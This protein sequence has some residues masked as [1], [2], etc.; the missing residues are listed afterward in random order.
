MV[1]MPPVDDFMKLFNF[2]SCNSYFRIDVNDPDSIKDESGKISK[3]KSKKVLYS[4]GAYLNIVD[5]I[6]PLLPKE[7]KDSKP[8]LK[9]TTQ[10]VAFLEVPPEE[11][12]RLKKMPTIVTYYP[13]GK[14]QGTYILPPILY[15]DGKY[16]LKLGHHNYFESIVTNRE[17]M[18]KW[19]EK[20]TGNE[21]AVETLANFIIKEFIPDLHV[22][23]IQGGCCVTA[24]VSW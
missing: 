11:A 21:E 20:G 8:A 22:L 12:K 2:A 3:I 6:Q 7:L 16:Y 14:L 15:P 24:K 5:L 23:S 18:Q 10:T 4:P 17:E 19:Y 13:Y 1:A 9:L